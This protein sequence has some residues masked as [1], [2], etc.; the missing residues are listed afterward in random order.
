MTQIN[1]DEKRRESE[2]Q[3][4]EPLMDANLR[5]PSDSFD[6]EDSCNFRV[7]DSYQIISVY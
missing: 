7:W 1:T 3:N 6:V 4:W 2:E 5:K